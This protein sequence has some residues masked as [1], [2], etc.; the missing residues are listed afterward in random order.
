MRKHHRW[1]STKAR[2]LTRSILFGLLLAACLIAWFNWKVSPLLQSYAAANLE[3]QVNQLVDEIIARDIEDGTVDYSS[4][5]ILEKNDQGQ[6]TA[7]Q[8]NLGE[9]NRLRARVITGLTEELIQEESTSFGIPVGNLTGISL[10]SSRGFRIPVEVQSV[11]T[12]NAEFE[13]QLIPAAVNQT[14]YM[15]NLKV[16]VTVSLLIPGGIRTLPIETTVTVAEAVLLGEVPES[17]TVFDNYATASDAGED[18]F[19]YG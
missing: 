2:Q 16:S 11:S 18:Y 15:L 3:N 1:R 9:A 19:N 8:S 7:L 4:I 6:I 17:Y 14:H 13:S 5:L 12:V 10:F